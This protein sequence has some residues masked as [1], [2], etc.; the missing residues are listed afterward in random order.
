MALLSK[1]AQATTNQ[2]DHYQSESILTSVP[3]KLDVEKVAQLT[4]EPTLK[5]YY[6]I[7]L[8]NYEKNEEGQYWLKSSITSDDAATLN[9]ILDEIGYFTIKGVAKSGLGSATSTIKGIFN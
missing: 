4:K 6:D 7:V 8:A 1:G 5:K 9:A 2:L 3:R